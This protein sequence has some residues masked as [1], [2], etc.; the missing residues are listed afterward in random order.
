MS[1]NKLK[2]TLSRA[3]L[4]PIIIAAAIV[5]VIVLLLVYGIFAM[6]SL[7]I[8]DILLCAG[9]LYLLIRYALRHFDSTL[10]FIRAC[11]K[12]GTDSLNRLKKRNLLD[13]ADAEYNNADAL[14]FRP[15]NSG[16]SPR[17]F[18]LRQNML[19]PNFIFIMAE[20]VVF[21]YDDVRRVSFC[22]RNSTDTPKLAGLSESCTVLQLTFADNSCFDFYV[23]KGARAAAPTED[24]ICR[25][26]IGIIE[27]LA[28]HCEI[29]LSIR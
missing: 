10:E 6:L 4:A 11:R 19:T 22:S 21:T 9:G 27:Q 28:P 25:E 20:N 1:G 26:I 14:R 15:E 3:P 23:C 2:T 13:H 5:L 17:S 7:R 29:D 8:I 12:N 18:T 24:I 16:F